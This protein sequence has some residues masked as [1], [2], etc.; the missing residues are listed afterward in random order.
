MAKARSVFAGFSLSEQTPAAAAP[1]EQRLFAPTPQPTVS[2]PV[3][4]T[5]SG[6]TPPAA[7]PPAAQESPGSS[8]VAA[9]DEPAVRPT[10]PPREDHTPAVGFDLAALPYR[11]DSF[12][13]TP[14][15]F[16]ALARLK[17]DLQ[18][19]LDT[20]VTKN[21]LIRC[22]V[23]YMVHDYHRRGAQSA[24]FTPLKKKSR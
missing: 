13:F 8:R 3:T 10:E 18:R 6:T 1:V 22:A 9:A 19:N 12:L 14:E 23:Q 5:D 7:P 15:E 2:P 16:D 21:D 17:L 11:K 20:K 24:I 4:I